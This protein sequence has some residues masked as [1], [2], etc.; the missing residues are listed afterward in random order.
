VPAW[1][2]SMVCDDLGH[3]IRCDLTLSYVSGALSPRNSSGRNATLRRARASREIVWRHLKRLALGK[4][5][6]SF[7]RHGPSCSH[8]IQ[9]VVS[10]Q[11]LLC[12]ANAEGNLKRRE[13]LKGS[14]SAP[15]PDANI[16]VSLGRLSCT[17]YSN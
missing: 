17:S 11:F 2:D 8:M 1:M 9:H 15:L 4:F 14:F 12:V 16:L 7:G 10:R 6:R 5:L 3:A 13:V